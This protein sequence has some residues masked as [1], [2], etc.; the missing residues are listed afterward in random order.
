[1]IKDPADRKVLLD[2]FL[3]NNVRDEERK[4]DSFKVPE[5]R[6]MDRGQNDDREEFKQKDNSL[7]SEKSVFNDS[8][9]I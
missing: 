2:E 9:S 4:D 8:I 5:A 1:M 7:F 6:E 3:P